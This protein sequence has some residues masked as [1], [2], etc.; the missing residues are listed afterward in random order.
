MAAETVPT[1]P[2]KIMR[3]P[4]KIFAKVINEMEI[5][6]VFEMSQISKRIQNMIMLVDIQIDCLEIVADESTKKICLRNHWKDPVILFIFDAKMGPS[7]IEMKMGKLT[8]KVRMKNYNRR[9]Y[10]CYTMH[11]E[12]M[13][14]YFLDYFSSIFR[15][16]SGFAAVEL[17]NNSAKLRPLTVHPIF[18][19]RLILKLSGKLK[20]GY[21]GLEML[22]H[23]FQHLEGIVVNFKFLKGS[24]DYKQMLSLKRVC[25]VNATWMTREDL[26]NSNTQCLRILLHKLTS[27]DLNAFIKHWLAG[28]NRK[29]RRL[30][31][32][33]EHGNRLDSAKVTKDL[34]VEMWSAFRR[35]SD[36]VMDRIQSPYLIDTS[37]GLDVERKDGLLATIIVR[38][39]SF[40]FCVWHCRF[41]RRL[42]G[43]PNRPFKLANNL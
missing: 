1:K 38:E 21:Q 30:E 20:S 16:R 5:I 11:F 9:E 29:L 2:F 22:L 4:K 39:S 23:Q 26:L 40:L 15:F 31:L 17:L 7:R 6:D 36:Y 28:N 24:F 3:L 10:F 12:T 32:L 13:L 42:P 41:N 43:Y 25:L 8:L 18:N 34:N 35:D 37:R 14:K 19:D 27:E 33:C